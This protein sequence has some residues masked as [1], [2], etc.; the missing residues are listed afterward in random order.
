MQK[1]ENKKKK[2]KPKKTRN[3]KNR[4]KLQSLLGCEENVK[5]DILDQE[6]M[7]MFFIE[8]IP[9]IEGDKGEA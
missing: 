3:K 8:R 6:V 2:K 1:L 7:P 5:E 4:K 9:I